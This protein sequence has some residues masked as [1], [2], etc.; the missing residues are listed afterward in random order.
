MSATKYQQPSVLWA[1]SE[2]GEDCACF[3]LEQAA[4]FRQYFR[5]VRA[6]NSWILM[7]ASQEV[8]SAREFVQ[9]ASLLLGLG[10]RVPFVIASDLTQGWLITEDFGDRRLLETLLQKPELATQ[11]YQ[12]AW[13]VLLQLQRAG[14]FS[15]LLPKMDYAFAK[16]ESMRL[17]HDFVPALSQHERWD[18]AA[19]E[20]AIELL[21]ESVVAQPFGL[22]HRDFHAANLMCLDSQEIGVLDFQSAFYAP[23]AYDIVSLLRD[24]YID[25]PD[26]EINHWL[27]LFFQDSALWRSHFQRF[28]DFKQAF[29]EVSLQRHLKC[30]GLFVHLVKKGQS[31]YLSALPRTL[32]YVRDVCQRDARWHPIL[33]VIHAGI[34]SIPNNFNSH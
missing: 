13:Q 1:L 15:P 16:R 28:S 4:S 10:L 22:A 27:R 31:L 24:C 25:W 18:L 17:L 2:L 20:R 8:E 7:D 19:I 23:M 6:N 29:D 9:V 14:D 12:K 26:H 11:W 32:R 21:S 3:A 34:A 33:P 30:L 5:F